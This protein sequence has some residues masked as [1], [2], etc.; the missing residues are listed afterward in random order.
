[1]PENFDAHDAV[2]IL[3]EMLAEN[4]DPY[5]QYAKAEDINSV[6]KMVNEIGDIKKMIGDIKKEAEL[7]SRDLG[8][9]IEGTRKYKVFVD[10]RMNCVNGINGKVERVDLKV[11]ALEKWQK[12]VNRVLS[13]HCIEDLMD[14]KT[15]NK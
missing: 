7:L 2:G 12:K 3:N 10:R 6:L 15:V 5:E 13:L 4:N 9:H 11:D 8:V 1:M 14:N